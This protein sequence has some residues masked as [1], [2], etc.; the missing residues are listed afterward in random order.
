[1]YRSRRQ[2]AC[3]DAINWRDGLD[4]VVWVRKNHDSKIYWIVLITNSCTINCTDGLDGDSQNPIPDPINPICLRD[5]VHTWMQYIEQMDKM[6]LLRLRKSWQE[7][8][9]LVRNQLYR[10]IR[11]GYTSL[12]ARMNYHI[13]LIQLNLLLMRFWSSWLNTCCHGAIMVTFIWKK[14]NHDPLVTS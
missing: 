10:W 7:K 2:N 3:L 6:I 8:L 9:M 1:M 12:K 14:T 13:Q 4:D 11:W 5:N